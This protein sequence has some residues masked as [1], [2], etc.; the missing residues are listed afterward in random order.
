MH[1]Q[2]AARVASSCVRALHVQSDAL[3]PAIATLVRASPEEYRELK[4]ALHAAKQAQ[5]WWPS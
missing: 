5:S 3:L 1:F 2:R 4:V